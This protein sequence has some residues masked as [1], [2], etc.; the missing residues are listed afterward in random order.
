MEPTRPFSVSDGRPSARTS[1]ACRFAATSGT[2]ASL[3]IWHPRTY[4]PEYRRLFLR[5]LR[6]GA[7]VVDAGAHIGT[8]TLL[9]C[10]AVGSTGRVVAIEADPY[11]LRALEPNIRRAGCANVT[12]VGKAVADAPGRARFQQSLGTISSSFEAR[13]GRGP[14]RQ[15]DIEV[16]SIDA[17][18]KDVDVDALV[19]KLDVEGAEPR[20]LIG[21]RE[22]IGRANSVALFLEVNPSALAA[23][24]SDAATLLAQVDALGLEAT[25]IGDERVGSGPHEP[26]LR[27]TLGRAP[28][29]A[30]RVWNGARLRDCGFVA[31]SRHNDWLC[32]PC[33]SS[34]TI[35]R[36]S[37]TSALTSG[38]RDLQRTRSMKTW[39]RSIDRTHRRLIRRRPRFVCTC[40][41]GG[42]SI[43]ISAP[44][45]F[46]AELTRSGR[47]ARYRPPHGDAGTRGRFDRRDERLLRGGSPRP[48]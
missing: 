6:P 17:E 46:L 27:A 12:I 18:L 15:L 43:R 3:R 28:R 5:E 7:T 2:G 1:T 11:N 9:A 45:S 41:S 13:A 42:F 26:A 19:V 47:P 37:T 36:S 4:Q 34:S 35:R 22:T 48:G 38:A 24:G 21:A 29:P 32:G 16:T 39:S 14:F 31:S 40:S 30:S 8:Y 25:T 44:S 20:A 33:V 10:R 23:S